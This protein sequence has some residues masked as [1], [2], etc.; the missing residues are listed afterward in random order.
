MRKVILMMLLAIVCSS[1][2]S[3]QAFAQYIIVER[4]P[5]YPNPKFYWPWEESP[6]EERERKAQEEKQEYA[7]K[8]QQYEH[9]KR[10]AR[11]DHNKPKKRS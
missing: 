6:E 4:Y 11:V 7:K 9:A 10:L 2:M 8:E 5:Y 1:A 3:P